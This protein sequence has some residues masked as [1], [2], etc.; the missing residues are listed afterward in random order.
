MAPSGLRSSCASIARNSSFD[1]LSRCTFVR[2]LRSVTISVRCSHVVD[3][4]VADRDVRLERRCGSPVAAAC[5]ACPRRRRAALAASPGRTA[6]T[7]R[8]IDDA[9]HRLERPP[10]S[11]AKALVGVE[12]VAARGEDDGAFL[13]LFDEVA[14]RLVGAVQRV[15]LIARVVVDEQRVDLAVPDRPQHLLGFGE[16]RAQLVES[17][18]R[19]RSCGWRAVVHRH[20]ARR[21]SSPS[22]TRS[23]FD[24]SPMIRRSGSG[25]FLIRVGAAMICSPLARTGCW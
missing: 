11:A 2:V 7:N 16:A 4:Y 14:V 3:A 17:R 20:H 5:A 19:R 21:R 22:S 23:V 1:W 12:D 6:S 8:S 24:M 18:R 9:D 15:D 13:H 10:T 25:S